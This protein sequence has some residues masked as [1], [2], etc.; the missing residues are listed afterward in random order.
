[1]TFTTEVELC[2]EFVRVKYTFSDAERDHRSTNQQ[3]IPAV[4]VEEGINRQISYDGSEPWCNRNFDEYYSTTRDFAFYPTEGWSA[5]IDKDGYGIAVINPDPD[6][7]RKGVDSRLSYTAIL[8]FEEDYEVAGETAC[9][10]GTNFVSPI[11]EFGIDEGETVEGV[12]YLTVGNIEDMR[13]EIY[14]YFS[15]K[16]V[17]CP[18]DDYSSI[19]LIPLERYYS[20][21]LSDH[22][23]TATHEA[24]LLVDSSYMYM[25]EGDLGQISLT[26]FEG[27]VP[28]R[29]YYN[30]YTGDHFYTTDFYEYPYPDYKLEGFTGF[31]CLEEDTDMG[32]DV[33]LWRY[34]NPSTGDHLYTSDYREYPEGEGYILE[35]G[36]NS[37]YSIGYIW[38]G[39]GGVQV[40]D[41]AVS[42]SSY[43]V[44]AV[45]VSSYTVNRDSNA[46]L[47]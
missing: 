22:L 34:Y 38:G 32:C 13:D 29:R 30:S 9:C 18:T 46:L 25:Y 17:S 36:S 20:Q 15:P 3:E 43:T 11:L 16:E 42:V 35:A 14:N 10:A 45:S 47:S 31:V 44:N 19:D 7:V 23:L 8:N 41:T 21:E 28:L 2:G 37:D 40:A 26:D 12:Y 27:S 5:L 4:Y 33:P 1:V 6:N 39:S 24:E